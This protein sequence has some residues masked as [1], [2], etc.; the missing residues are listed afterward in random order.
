MKIILEIIKA[1][2]EYTILQK[3]MQFDEEGGQ[4]GR[5]KE[6]KWILEDH[7]KQISNFHAQISYKGM[8]YITDISSNGTFFKNPY[9]K[10]VKGV[11]MPLIEGNTLSIGMYDIAVKSIDGAMVDNPSSSMRDNTFIPDRVFTGNEGIEAL[12]VLNVETHESSNILALLGNEP[13]ESIEILPDLGSIMSLDEEYEQSNVITQDSLSMH[14]DFDAIDENDD[15]VYEQNDALNVFTSKLGIN[16]DGKSIKEQELFMSEMAVLIGTL[17]EETHMMANNLNKAKADLGVFGVD[18]QTPFTKTTE[19]N[20]LLKNREVDGQT[21]AS[22]LKTLFKE[23]TVHNLAFFQAYKNTALQTS[24]QFSPDALY[25]TFTKEN[26]LKKPLLS[27]KAQAWEAYVD[28][29]QYL[30]NNEQG[31]DVLQEELRKAYLEII[32][33]F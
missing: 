30:N 9:K 29:F 12:D 13:E 15:F 7:T 18:T 2:H 11:P 16:F 23:V 19:P 20:I 24:T 32:K 5:N 33:D 14:I 27:K 25:R 31:K 3:T 6:S 8:Y 4:I 10:F 28:K 21:L 22:H 17:L 1:P 26:K